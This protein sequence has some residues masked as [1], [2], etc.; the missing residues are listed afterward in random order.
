MGNFTK[1][2][3]YFVNVIKDKFK[4]N[5]EVRI[6]HTGFTKGDDGSFKLPSKLRGELSFLDIK[7][8]EIVNATIII[9]KRKEKIA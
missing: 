5:S 6:L 1:R 2:Y 3:S 7:E 9:N 4:S 8:D